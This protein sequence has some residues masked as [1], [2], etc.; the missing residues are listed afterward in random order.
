MKTGPAAQASLRRHML[1]YLDA[2]GWRVLLDADWDDMAR[3][4]LRHW[5][6]HDLPLV[7]AR[8]R[9]ADGAGAHRLALGLSA[10]EQW[11]RRR[12]ALQVAP[13]R[14]ARFGEFPLLGEVL[15]ELPAAARPVL[16]ELDIA[17][18]GHG[19]RARAYGSAGWQRLS[20]LRH[21]HA[22]S[23][24]DLWL[25]VA[26]ADAADQAVA[27]LQRHAPAG[28]RL[29][30]E[31]VF[32]DGGAVAWRE[33]QA[34]REGRCGALLVKRLHGAR[35]EASPWSAPSAQQQQQQALAA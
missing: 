28:L 13:A 15:D 3:A 27:A 9:L 29:D 16:H 2:E 5:S 21:L 19:L 35:L 1:A 23:D 30:G 31:L 12:L 10:P 24:L 20:G 25:G 6:A 14:I 34:W 32:A 7:V 8:Q 17:L 33:W 26:T 18:A 11:G 22:G 4:C